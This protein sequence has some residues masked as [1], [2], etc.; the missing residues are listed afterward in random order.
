MHAESTAVTVPM[1]QM[2]FM[3]VLTLA[4][5][6]SDLLE[7]RALEQF[8]MLLSNVLQYLLAET[9]VLVCQD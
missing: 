3:R 6:F 9:V 8:G 7:I 5:I 1:N 2:I 4:P